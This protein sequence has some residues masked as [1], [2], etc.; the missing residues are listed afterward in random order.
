MKHLD[1]YPPQ[2]YEE[3]LRVALPNSLWLILAG[4][5]GVIHSLV[6]VLMPFYTSTRIIKSFKVLVDTER[7]VPEF[8]NILGTKY[9]Q[10]Q[11]LHLW[12]KRK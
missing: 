12:L 6:P 3:H 7:H 11:H 5:A 10:D 9:L 2:T 1:E 8:N 4:F